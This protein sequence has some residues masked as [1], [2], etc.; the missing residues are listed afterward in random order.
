MICLFSRFSLAVVV[1]S[2]KLNII[3]SAFVKT[4]ESVF[5]GPTKG[6]LTD[7]GGEIEIGT[8]IK[9]AGGLGLKFQNTA[10]YSPQSNGICQRH[11]RTLTETLREVREDYLSFDIFTCVSLSCEKL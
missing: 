7:N 1:T 4:L 8:M 9:L 3:I 2:N 6:I 11:S 5:G 10:P